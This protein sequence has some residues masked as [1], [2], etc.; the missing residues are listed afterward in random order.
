MTPV[1]L[2]SIRGAMLISLSMSTCRGQCWW[3]TLSQGMSKKKKRD[4]ML[5][6]LCKCET[7]NKPLPS[8]WVWRD[9]GASCSV[10]RHWGWG[11]GVGCS[12]AEWHH[13]S[14]NDSRTG[15]LGSHAAEPEAL[16]VYPG[17][18]KKHNCDSKENTRN[19]GGIVN[20]V[21]ALQS[22]CET[23]IAKGDVQEQQCCHLPYRGFA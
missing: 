13:R 20:I 4:K 16:A 19:Q 23:N 3:E 17:T 5:L 9:Q 12:W 7:P 22:V 21:A 8:D 10:G 6:L 14:R 1:K 2:V 18:K 11:C 15:T